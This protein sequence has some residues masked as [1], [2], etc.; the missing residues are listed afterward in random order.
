M[1]CDLFFS[2]N[3]L[4]FTTDRPGNEG[5]LEVRPEDLCA[6]VGAAGAGAQVRQY[7]TVVF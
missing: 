1:F 6:A 2:S 4:G 5:P 7:G 3:K